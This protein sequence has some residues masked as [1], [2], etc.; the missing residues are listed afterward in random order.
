M[1]TIRKKRTEVSEYCPATGG[2]PGEL[3][4]NGRQN[5]LTCIHQRIHCTPTEAGGKV[6]EPDRI[7]IEAFLNTLSEV[8]LSVAS[9][10]LYARN[11]AEVT[12]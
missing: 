6:S 9:R 4:Q 11:D 8:A 1:L 10:R 12:R 2:I 3:A 7:M 5:P